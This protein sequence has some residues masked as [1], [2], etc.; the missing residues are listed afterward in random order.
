[1]LREEI[2]SK[3]KISVATCKFSHR[4]SNFRFVALEIPASSRK[5]RAGEGRRISMHPLLEWHPFATSV[6][7]VDD[8]DEKLKHLTIENEL[9]KK[10][11]KESNGRKSLNKKKQKKETLL[12]SNAGD[13]TAAV[14]KKP[15]REVWVRYLSGRGFMQN[16]QLFDSV[17]IVATGSGIA[18]CLGYADEERYGHIE[19]HLLW[20]GKQHAE[21][22]GAELMQFVYNNFTSVSLLDTSAYKKSTGHYPDI[23]KEA[24]ALFEKWKSTEAVFIVS[25][26][27]LTYDC[28]KRLEHSGIS[29]YGAIWDS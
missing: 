13:W 21:I 27:P 2:G 18:P 11:G 10:E 22:Y 5:V 20:V 14:C 25:N 17:V 8:E 26:Q 12:I 9:E 1:M 23:A 29:A 7:E 4:N 15:P 19:R 3:T 24:G 16:V 6:L 28:V